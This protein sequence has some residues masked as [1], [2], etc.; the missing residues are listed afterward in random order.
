[1]ITIAHRLHTIIDTDKILCLS[2]GRI[3]NY[4]HPYELL[5]DRKT[6]LYELAHNLD[7]SELDRLKE[8]AK[9]KYFDS[10]RNIQEENI[11]TESHNQSEHAAN[12]LNENT[13]S[14]NN[15]ADS[16]EKQHLLEK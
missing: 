7:K 5:Q 15:L 9:A 10:N 1:M 2:K 8:L 13:F 16:I 4:A 12:S 14:D 11:I 6:V 3:E